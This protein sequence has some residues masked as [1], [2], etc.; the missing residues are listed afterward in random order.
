M[1]YTPQEKMHL[2]ENI[3]QIGSFL[4]HFSIEI[5]KDELEAMK[6]ALP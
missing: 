3:M 6:I 1:L 2:S 4:R 5:C